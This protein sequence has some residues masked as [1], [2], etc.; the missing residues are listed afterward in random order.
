MSQPADYNAPLASTSQTIIVEESSESTATLVPSITISTDSS[1]DNVSV[2]LNSPTVKTV[3]NVVAAMSATTPAGTGKDNIIVVVNKMDGGASGGTSGEVKVMSKP[4]VIGSPGTP[5]ILKK[6]PVMG[7]TIV[8][9]QKASPQGTASAA[10]L[11]KRS[12]VVTSRPGVNQILACA[13]GLQ[14]Q[15][16]QPSHGSTPVV[17]TQKVAAGGI[18]TSPV[19]STGGVNSAITNVLGGTKIVATTGASPQAQPQQRLQDVRVDNWGNYCL[20]RLQTMYDKGDYCDLTLR[21]HSSQEI[22]VKKYYIFAHFCTAEK[23]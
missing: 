5:A 16:Q 21:F 17:L 23:I 8:K 20:Q 12:I 13:P 7:N 4:L 3:K 9:V 1:K 11:G 10:A 19:V 18:V 22:K 2:K 15:Q 6:G 14:Q